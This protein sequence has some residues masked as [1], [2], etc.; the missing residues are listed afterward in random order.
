LGTFNFKA[1]NFPNRGQIKNIVHP[2][3][4]IRLWRTF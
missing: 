1:K 2:S 3:L 4:L